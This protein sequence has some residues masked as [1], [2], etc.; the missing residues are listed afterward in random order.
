MNLLPII[1][2]PLQMDHEIFRE[3]PD[4]HGLHSLRP[5]LGLGSARIA[6]IVTNHRRLELLPNHLQEGHSLLC[7]APAFAY[8]RDPLE[9]R[10]RLP[11]M[12]DIL[13][14]LAGRLEMEETVEEMNKRAI[15][16]RKVLFPLA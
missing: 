10:E 11:A 1:P 2:E 13:T 12:R 5:S 4:G 15:F 9:L 6:I 3:S 7:P 8:W 16:L 14:A